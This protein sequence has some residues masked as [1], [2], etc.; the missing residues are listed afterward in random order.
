MTRWIVLVAAGG[1]AGCSQYSLR[2]ED[3]SFCQIAEHAASFEGRKVRFRSQIESDG[4]HGSYLADKGCGKSI[5]I[6]TADTQGMN[7]VN[8]VIYT[9]GAPGT[10]KKSVSAIWIGRI[11]NHGSAVFLDVERVEDVSYRLTSAWRKSG[12]PP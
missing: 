8:E 1:I 6:G 7:A 9:V 2:M 10:M 5:A 11:R 3:T 12:D 4:L